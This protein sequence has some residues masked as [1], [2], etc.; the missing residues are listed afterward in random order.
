MVFPAHIIEFVE[1]LY[2]D[3]EAT[4][5]MENK[6]TEWFTIDQGVRQ[7]HILSY[8]DMSYNI[9]YMRKAFDGPYCQVLVGGRTITNLKYAYDTTLSARTSE[10]LPELM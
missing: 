5:R 10:E 2:Q 1:L 8:N 6:N 3:Q 4:V 7:G 9:I